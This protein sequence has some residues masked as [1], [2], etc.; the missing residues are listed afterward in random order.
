MAVCCNS[1]IFCLE[2]P[3]CPW[4]AQESLSPWQT[5]Q[6]Y[7]SWGKCACR[8]QILGSSQSR[9]TLLTKASCLC[10]PQRRRTE[11]SLRSS[12]C[13]V[14]LINL[15]L[16]CDW[17]PSQCSPSSTFV[18]P[19][20]TPAPPSQLALATWWM[21]WRQGQLAQLLLLGIARATSQAIR[22]PAELSEIAVCRKE[23]WEAHSLVFTQ[24]PT[25]A[26]KC[27][28]HKAPI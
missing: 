16:S 9:C 21:C 13:C 18:T 15:P 20:A 27:G 19:R 14:L 12:P 5:D 1:G 3:L 17:E 2:G 25:W 24:H 11:G 26:R 22:G 7:P 23:I 28:G 8:Q 6:F 4:S 10:H